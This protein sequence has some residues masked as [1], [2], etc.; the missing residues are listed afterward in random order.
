MLRNNFV[1]LSEAVWK[2]APRR[3]KEVYWKIEEQPAPKLPDR[4]CTDV[5]E[6]LRALPASYD[7]SMRTRRATWELQTALAEK[8]RRGDL[9]ARGFRTHPNMGETLEDI[10]HHYFD[11]AQINWKRNIVEK[12]GRRYEAVEVCYAGA[13][14]DARLQMQRSV[15]PHPSTEKKR[16]RPSRD[17][18]IMTAISSLARFGH[19]FAN[20]RR[21]ISWSKIIEYL[22]NECGVTSRDGL[23]DSVLDRCIRTHLSTS[24]IVSKS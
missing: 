22:E 4:S 15:V 9:T 8:L 14:E 1:P 7:H 12:F 18:L 20:T 3:L 10:P 2:Y 11:H 24:K 6:Y 5:A 21:K 23:S 17:H 16:G 19:D 13:I